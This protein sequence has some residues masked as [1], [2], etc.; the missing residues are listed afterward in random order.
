M[1]TRDEFNSLKAELKQDIHAIVQKVT[2]LQNQLA[3]GNPITDQDMQDLRDDITDLT[4]GGPQP[5]PQPA[6]SP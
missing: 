5:G 3:A 2:D 6:P 4:G 1:A